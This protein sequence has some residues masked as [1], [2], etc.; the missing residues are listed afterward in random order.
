LALLKISMHNIKSGQPCVKKKL[1]RCGEGL[2]I[3]WLRKREINESPGSNV[4]SLHNASVRTRIP[5]VD[6]GGQ[7]SYIGQSNNDAGP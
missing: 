4:E 5:E 2:P 3:D 6:L 7:I 1:S